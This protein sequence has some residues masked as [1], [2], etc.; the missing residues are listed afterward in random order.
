M[1]LKFLLYNKTVDL[2]QKQQGI[3]IAVLL[4]ILLILG[5]LATTLVNLNSQSVQSNA[6]QVIAIRAFFAAES[7][8]H[9]QAMSIFPISGAG[10]CSNQNFT[11]NVD[12]LNGCTATTTCSSTTVNA[13]TY[14]QVSSTGQCNS[15]NPFQAT[16]TINIRLRDLN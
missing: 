15:G 1:F 6:Q 10:S 2:P 13:Q 11:F 7:G 4:F 5:L 16:R 8:A 9:R 12:G 14:Y 3:S